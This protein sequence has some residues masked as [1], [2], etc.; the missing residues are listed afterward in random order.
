MG[1]FALLAY[2]T[3]PAGAILIGLW[4]VAAALFLRPIAWRTLALA[5]AVLVGAVILGRVLPAL[6]SGLGQPQP[7]L[8]HSTG[9]LTRRLLDLQWRQWRRVLFVVIPG[10]ILPALTLLL[11]PRLD[12]VAR[13]LAAVTVAQFGFFYLQRRTSL[14]YFAPAMILPLAVCWRALPDLDRRWAT[15]VALAA[16][17]VALVISLPANRSPH[18]AA[19][20]IGARI[21]D[22]LGGYDEGDPRVFQRSELLSE[23]FHRDSHGAVPAREYGGSPLSWIY[24][25]HRAP[26]A[27]PAYVLQSETDR[28]P[29]GGRLVAARDAAAL[30]VVDEA[31]FQRDRTARLPVHIAAVYQLPKQTLFAR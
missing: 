20:A 23:L 5:S 6:Q 1:A 3:S 19:R 16:A 7:G 18:L 10:G 4:L 30:Y 31:A 21:D 15:P 12:R 26:G 2:F 8:E 22:R 13:T 29:P 25:A 9:G 14:H 17:A 11:W 28:P 27:D 24:Y